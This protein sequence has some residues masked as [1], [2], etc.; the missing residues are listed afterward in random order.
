M[1]S[2]SVISIS[3]Q[4]TGVFSVPRVPAS[5]R[6][7]LNQIL[8]ENHERY[9]PFFNDKGFHNHITHYMLASY[10]LG[11]EPEQ[12]SRAWVQEKA[13]QRPQHTLNEENVVRMKNT[14]FFISCLGKEEYYRDFLIFFQQE[15]GQ[16]GTGAVVNQYVFDRTEVSEAL[17]TRLFASFLHPLIHLGYGVEFNQPAIVAEAL[18]QTA[19]HH[20]EV[21]I[22]MKGCEEA[23]NGRPD[24]A[25]R[26]MNELL[27]KV[28][29]T[30]SIRNAAC[31]GDGSW[32]EDN[33]L[34]SAPKELLEIA[35]RWRVTQEELFEKTAEMINVNAFFCGAAQN[36]PKEYKIDFFFIH[37]LNCSI[38]FPS[39]LQQKWLSLENKVRLLEWKGRFD[40]VAYAAR[41]SPHLDVNEIID[42]QPKRP[43]TGWVD[44]FQRV[45]SF[46]D[47]S[48][49]TKFLRAL[50]HG[51]R[52][53]Q[54]Y[55][56]I[57][58]DRF[59]M[60]GGLWLQVAHM[61]MDTTEKEPIAKNRWV[62]G[63]GFPS[64]WDHFHSRH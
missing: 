4:D 50:A 12:L 59:P 1:A 8:Q 37:N 6:T 24:L 16:K 47:D 48:H 35:A 62:R 53:C 64:Q 43:G 13:F 27:G 10:A 14:Q 41:G 60:K 45:H 61:A 22:V 39:F 19:V 20:N 26:T 56:I 51:S 32:I 63:A 3:P 46:D 30:D 38:F 23:A 9:H 25:T 36:P 55:D 29:D 52:F 49:V 44:L 15:I 31:W 34:T 40:I 28:R 5:S 21:A 33:P 54:G 17:F 42:Y 7:T 58:G 18:A 57:N 2:H 11:A